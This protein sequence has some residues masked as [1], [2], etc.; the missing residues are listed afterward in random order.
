MGC[1]NELYGYLAIPVLGIGLAPKGGQFHTGGLGGKPTENPPRNDCTVMHGLL[2]LHAASHDLL[3]RR[4]L[5]EGVT[6]VYETSAGYIDIQVTS[7]NTWPCVA[8]HLNFL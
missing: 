2:L 1:V 8:R 4:A 6:A 3:Q 7:R 5:D